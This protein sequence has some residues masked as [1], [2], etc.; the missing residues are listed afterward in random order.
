[1]A[2]MII[3]IARPLVSV[4]WQSFH[5]TQRVFRDV[6]VE[7]CTPGFSRQI[8]KTGS[9]HRSGSRRARASRS[10]QTSLRRAGRAIG[11]L[12][13]PDKVVAALGDGWD[14]LSRVLHLDFYKALRFT[15]TFT[16]VT[17]PFVVGFGLLIALMVDNTARVAARP[18][19]FRVAAALHH[20]AGHRRA[21]DPLAVHRAT[22]S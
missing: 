12:L 11:T 19:H 8:C 22:A 6:T 10:R 13:Q 18:D 3:F 9:A 7:S 14:G 15:L 21:V 20:H 17:L 2:M 1:M 5:N 16:L 4:V